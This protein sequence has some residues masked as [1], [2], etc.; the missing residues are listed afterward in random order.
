MV[1]RKEIAA[2]ACCLALWTCGAAERQWPQL[3]EGTLP[4]TEVSTNVVL[5]VDAERLQTFRLRLQAES[6][7]S[8]EV[9]VAVGCDADGDGD[10]SFDEA[11]FA[12]GCDC[13]VRYFA[14][15]ETGEALEGVGDTLVVGRRFFD[16]TWNLAKV[17]KRIDRIRSDTCIAQTFLVERRIKTN[18]D[19]LLKFLNLELLE[20]LTW[21]GF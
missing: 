19:S 21:H 17:V 8:N 2:M 12:F 4:D 3:P 10:L 14:N 6:C 5:N 16:P 7:A 18:L 11:A 20:L 13:G 15:Y 1:I 9:V